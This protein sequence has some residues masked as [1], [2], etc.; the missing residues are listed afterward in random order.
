VNKKI[1]ALTIILV[2]VIALVGITSAFGIDG[3][4]KPFFHNGNLKEQLNEAIENEDYDKWIKIIEE[5]DFPHKE[6]F[7][8]V[9]T[10]ENF[11]Q[12][13]ALRAAIS[14]GD[15]ETAYQ[16]KEDLGIKHHQKRF[17]RHYKKFGGYNKSGQCN[18]NKNNKEELSSF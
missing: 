8:S 6:R 13:N 17:S 7:T 10:E 12:L 15:F 14:S 1:F 4:K 2:V 9:I 11:S 18:Y 16:I 3:S 5:N